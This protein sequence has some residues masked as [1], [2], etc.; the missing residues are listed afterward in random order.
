MIGIVIVSHSKQLALGVREL[1]AQMVQGQVPIAV[2]AGIEDPDNPLGTDPIQVYEAIA[3]VFSDNGVLVLMD[4]GSAL[5]SAEMAIEFLP[6]AQQQKVYLCEAP[7]VEGA[8][9]AVVAVAA[10]RDIQQ[11]MAEARGALL[12]KA[13]QLGVVSRPLSLVSHNTPTT[14]IESPTRE[15]RL[16]VS[17]RLGLHARPAAQFVTT[18]ARF[19]SQILVQNLTRNTELVRGDSINQVA[20]LGVRQGHELLIT[21]TGSDADEALAALQGLFANNFGEDNVAL[22]SPPALHHEVTPAIHGELLG[23]AA[24]A[25]VAIAPVVHYQPTHISI[26]EYH[27]DDPDAEWQR[28]Q[29][30]I[31]TARQEMQAV[32]SQASLQIGD[33]EAAIFDAQLLFLEDP[34]LLEAAH[35][36]ILEHHINAEAAWQAVV[37][38]VATSYRTLEDSYLQER[39][40]DV[41]DVG[42]RVLRLLAGNAPANL[43][44]EEPAILVA[45]D[46]SPSDTARLDPKKVLG[47]CT[48]SGSATSHSAIIARTLGIPAVLG[49]DAQVL[50]L[51]DG[52]LMALD[53]ESGKAWV[54]PESHIL[55][56][57]AAKQLAWQ[58]A[59]QEARATAHQPAITRDGRQVSVFANIGSIND[60]QVAVANGAEGVGLLRTEFLYLDRTSAPTEEEQLEVYQAIAQVLDNRPLII[61]TLDVGGDKPLP[62]LRVGFPE[63]NPFLGWRGIRFCLDHLDLF[64]TQ[65]RAILR[66]SVGHQIKIML[67]MIA[68]VTEVRA[69]KV[70]LGEVQAELN[71]AG[72]SFDAAMKVGIMVEVPAA[73]A[74]A[75]Q[76]A[77]EVD[78][79]SIGTND[80][81]Q[82]VMASD[83]TNPRVANLVDALHPAVL[84]MVQQT[85]QAAHAAGISVGLCGELAADTLATPI[86]LGLGLDELSVNPQSIPGVK[87]AIARF[88]IVESE[89]IVASALQQDSAVNVRKLISTSVIPPA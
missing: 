4:L 71:Q 18:A 76:L 57:L 10:G 29:A 47:I 15:I 14:N 59:Q 31:H 80:L 42:Q 74:I 63:A 33:A 13:T 25:G 22:N 86:L 75:D 40:D 46:L 60:V 9:A 48:T 88:C 20:T 43:H 70:I 41:V 35:Q 7:L 73:V 32:F 55:D 11:V 78:F 39:V 16:I 45:T 52:T 12:A 72:I 87:Q 77:A 89:A 51:A 36:R 68:S 62:Y 64:K 85:I 81:S 61:R 5:L 54:E 65:L 37:D 82:Y 21:A 30:A 6:E 2:A 24:S 69:A 44:L 1:A 17:N 67:P 23:I 53:G 28:V 34:V 49:V 58:T 83:R 50:H 27:V 3:S 26:T 84:R 19:Q 56:L 79:F 8:I 38:E 66:A